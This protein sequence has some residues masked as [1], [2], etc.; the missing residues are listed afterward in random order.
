MSRP[1]RASTNSGFD[2]DFSMF[3]ENVNEV[4]GTRGK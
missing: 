3:L 1:D 2:L 4:Q